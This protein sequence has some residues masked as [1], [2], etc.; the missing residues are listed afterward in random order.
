MHVI[1]LSND[2]ILYVLTFLYPTNWL[3]MLVLGFYLR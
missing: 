2:N 3:K 1:T